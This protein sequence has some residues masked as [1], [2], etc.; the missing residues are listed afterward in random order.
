MRADLHGKTVLISGA[1]YNRILYPE[2]MEVLRGVEFSI[3]HH[4]YLRCPSAARAMTGEHSPV[5]PRTGDP[6]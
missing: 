3:V 5:L 6:S 2:I 1:L 4:G